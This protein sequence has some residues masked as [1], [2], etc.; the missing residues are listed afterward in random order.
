[1][2]KR[3]FFK[4]SEQVVKNCDYYRV[5]LQQELDHRRRQQSSQQVHT[6]YQAPPVTQLRHSEPLPPILPP[7]TP[8]GIIPAYPN[9]WKHLPTHS[10]LLAIN[11][12]YPERFNISSPHQNED[13]HNHDDPYD[14]LEA[15]PV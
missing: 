3:L 14:G 7:Y 1:M 11:P 9:Q 15:T 5:A 4:S 10:N 13:M 2:I 8:N 6:H 12:I